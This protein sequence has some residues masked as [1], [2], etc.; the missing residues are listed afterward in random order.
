MMNQCLLRRR[1]TAAGVLLFVLLVNVAAIAQQAAPAAASQKGDPR[2]YEKDI[3]AFLAADQTAPPQK[4]QILFIG[5]SIFRLWK[6]L[7]EQMAPLPVFNRAYGGSR[8]ADILFY[9]DKVV[10]PYEPK[11]IV[12]YCGSNDINADIPPETIF[13][14]FREFADRV[15]AKLPKTKIFYVSINKAPQKMERWD[16]VDDANRRIKE[17]C[18]KQA[19]LGFIDVN[20]ALFDKDGK[21]R[22]ELY[23]PD[24]LHFQEP[25]YAEFTRIIKPVI[26]QAWKKK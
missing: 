3:E 9:M 21:P 6:N 14:S 2:R 15:H 5:S 8:T 20:P 1:M 18:E 7:K 19:T 4:G 17:F 11:I 22:M 25:A 13:A 12:Y 24:K 10:L 16:W 26:E 23:L